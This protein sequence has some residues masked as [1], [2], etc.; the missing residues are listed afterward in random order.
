MMPPTRNEREIIRAIRAQSP[1]ETGSVLKGIG[2]DC[3]VLR[4]D[5]RRL[6]VLTVDTL[7]ESVHFDLGW[8]PPDL[9]GRKAA[10]VNLSDIAAMGGKPGFALLSLAV[11][12]NLAA[13][14]LDRFMSGFM[15]ALAAAQVVLVGGDTVQS[16]GQLSLSVTV[17]GEVDEGDVLYRSGAQVGDLIWVSG[18]LGEAAAGLAICREGKV[19]DDPV[20]QQLVKAHLDPEPE[21]ELGPLLAESGYPHAMM[22]LSDGIATD[23]AHL[24]EA[25]GVGAELVAEQL[26][27][28]EPL[29]A[30]AGRL[31]CAALDWALRGGEDYRLL[32]TAPA[33]AT[34]PIENLVAERLGREIFCVGRIVE[35]S[36]VALCDGSSRRDISYQGYDH[37][38]S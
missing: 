1:V 32:F 35:G 3:A 19:A 13:Q 17:G 6:Q 20:W 10:A 18:P 9:L 12:P 36:G 4:L 23:L 22:D 7:I 33:E 38:A 2:D 5:G 24:C 30:A 34:L 15:E 37:F 11:P 31:K 29:R 21:V 8:H 25:S 26:P 14:W 16:G 27:L 28:S